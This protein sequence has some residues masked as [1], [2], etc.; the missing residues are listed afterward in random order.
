MP[1]AMQ[2]GVFVTMKHSNLSRRVACHA[3]TWLFAI[4]TAA[5]CAGIYGNAPLGIS[6]KEATDFPDA[7]ICCK[8]RIDEIARSEI[9]SPN[10]TLCES[11]CNVI[12]A[13]KGEV[14]NSVEIEF[15]RNGN[16]PV[17]PGLADVQEGRVYLVMLSGESP[18]YRMVA[19]MRALEDAVKP[20]YGLRPGDQ[21][22]AE[23]AAIC[24][25]GDREMKIDA[26]KQIGMM[27]DLRGAEFVAAA[28]QSAD[29]KTARAGVIAQYRMRIAPDVNRVME[30][31]DREIMET[32]YQESGRPFKDADGNYQ[33]RRQGRSH[34]MERGVPDFDYAT[35]V[36]VGIKSALARQ[37]EHSLYLFFGV[38]WKV[39][40]K[41]CVPVL[42]DL[43]NHSDERVRWQAVSSLTHTVEDRDLPRRL[44]TA[45]RE[46]AA[47]T[48]WKT[49]WREK[50]DDFMQAPTPPVPIR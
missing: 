49:W 44:R 18:P 32:W 22:L 20:T 21:L 26:V 33:F 9:H 31:F 29:S 42:I 50:G 46:E 4:S 14:G 17:L 13:L 35:Y 19:A 39:Q 7:T 27:R 47:L 37:D 43:L 3:V 25:S 23:L 28:A 48:K 8:V 24:R 12:S 34:V 16:G 15:R 41:E 36:E 6:E 38:P 1:E 2:A 40:R 30:L 11:T 5:A 10:G 45:S